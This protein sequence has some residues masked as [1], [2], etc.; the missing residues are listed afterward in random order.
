[1][2]PSHYFI[3]IELYWLSAGPRVCPAARPARLSIPAP[4]RAEV[5]WLRHRRRGPTRRERQTG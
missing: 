5:A 3:S 2:F 1:M 4:A